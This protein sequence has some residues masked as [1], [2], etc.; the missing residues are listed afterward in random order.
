MG[1][2]IAEVEAVAVIQ[3]GHGSVF[4]IAQIQIAILLGDERL[5]EQ[6]FELGTDHFSQIL[7]KKILA[8]GKVQLK[9]AVAEDF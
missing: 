2:Q 1:D 4:V 9:M 3:T 6:A 5:F 8:V 7:F